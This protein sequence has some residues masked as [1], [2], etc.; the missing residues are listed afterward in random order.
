ME[1][2]AAFIWPLS[3]CSEKIPIPFQTTVAFVGMNYVKET[4]HMG[5]TFNLTERVPVLEN[6]VISL[7]DSTI[8]L[9]SEE[10]K[11][12]TCSWKLRGEGKEAF[13]SKIPI[14]F[15]SAYSRAKLV[16]Q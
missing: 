16:Q 5:V 4:N 10:K 2:L 7:I 1:K 11:T 6:G 14:R 12:D 15:Y 8:T 3:R 13:L 9:F